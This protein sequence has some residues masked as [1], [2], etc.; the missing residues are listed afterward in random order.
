MISLHQVAMTALLAWMVILA[1]VMV[2][3]LIV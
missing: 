2:Y 1:S 3:A